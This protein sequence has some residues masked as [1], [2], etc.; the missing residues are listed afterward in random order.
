MTGCLCVRNFAC[1]F[2][3]FLR[4]ECQQ[5][6]EAYEPLIVALLGKLNLCLGVRNIIFIFTNL[7]LRITL[8]DVA[9]L[10]TLKGLSHQIFNPLTTRA[11]FSSDFEILL[12]TQPYDL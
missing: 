3:A 1:E 12:N 7:F 2:L 9:F 4:P 11:F 5:L 10:D 8:K 6:V